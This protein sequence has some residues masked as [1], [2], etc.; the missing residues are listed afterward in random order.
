MDT[1]SF[2]FRH[3]IEERLVWCHD[4]EQSDALQ[5][6]ALHSVALKRT[7]CN[8]RGQAERQINCD[9]PFAGCRSL[10]CHSAEWRGAISVSVK[11]KHLNVL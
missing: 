3:V 2:S 1:R 6:D 8:L 4:V 9:T 5:N 10:E 7:A 11:T